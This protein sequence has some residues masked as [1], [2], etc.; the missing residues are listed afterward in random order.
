MTSLPVNDRSD[1]NLFLVYKKTCILCHTKE[2]RTFPKLPKL[3][4]TGGCFYKVLIRVVVLQVTVALIRRK[5][6]SECRLAESD[7]EKEPRAQHH[8]RV[9]R[10]LEDGGLQQQHGGV[11]VSLPSL[12]LALGEGVGP[13]SVRVVGAEVVTLNETKNCSLIPLDV[14]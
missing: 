3:S 4:R 2:T 5:G 8:L 6:S 14:T 1:L 9:L 12:L 10:V 7:L 11:Q 13:V